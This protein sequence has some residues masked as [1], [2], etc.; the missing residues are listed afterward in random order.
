M[1]EAQPILDVESI[2][3]NNDDDDDENNDDSDEKEEDEEIKFQDKRTLRKILHSYDTKKY[4]QQWKGKPIN[5][6]DSSDEDWLITKAEAN[7]GNICLLQI[8]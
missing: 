2:N 3:E 8:L 4:L 7:K 1:R 5:S 6:D